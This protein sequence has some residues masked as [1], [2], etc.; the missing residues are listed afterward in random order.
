MEDIDTFTLHYGIYITAIIEVFNNF[1]AFFRILLGPCD[2]SNQED[3]LEV[4]GCME[5]LSSLYSSDV[6]AVV[7]NKIIR[8]ICRH[9]TQAQNPSHSRIDHLHWMPRILLHKN[10]SDL[11]DDLHPSRGSLFP[12]DMN[13]NTR[14]K[15]CHQSPFR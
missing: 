9:Q 4:V 7:Y 14:S 12:C 13:S 6:V 3:S 2:E 1:L 15:H 11:A 8:R 10:V 5:V